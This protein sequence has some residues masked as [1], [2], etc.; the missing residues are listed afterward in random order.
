MG[1]EQQFSYAICD[2]YNE[3]QRNSNSFFYNQRNT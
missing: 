1:N 2:F 3:S